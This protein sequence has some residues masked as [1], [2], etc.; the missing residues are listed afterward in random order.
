[1]NWNLNGHVGYS[2]P[3][4]SNF[5]IF[6]PSVS[7]SVS[8][9]FNFING[10][11]NE[12]NSNNYRLNFNL[13][14]Q[15]LK[16]V[17]VDWRANVGLNNQNTSLQPHLNS[18]NLV[19]GTN[20]EIKYYLPFKF[21]LMQVT[22]YNLVGKTKVYPEPIHQFYMNLELNKKMLKSQDLIVSVKAFDIFNTFNNINRSLGGSNYAETQEI[23]LTQYFMV[24]LKWDFNKNLGKKSDE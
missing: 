16:T 21:D 7:S 11:L 15:T 18:N 12:T 3:V 6:S 9:N 8:R 10:E 19:T 22:H 14:K 13:Q 1:M 24:G 2:K 4:F 17:D 20:L 23:V 5:M